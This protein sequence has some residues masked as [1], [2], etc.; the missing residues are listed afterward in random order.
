M[1]PRAVVDPW[2]GGRTGATGLRRVGG[3]GRY[4]RMSLKNHAAVHAPPRRRVARPLSLAA[5]ALAALSVAA[6]VVWASV[7]RGGSPDPTAPGVGHLSGIVDIGVL[8]FREGLETI[9]VLTAI[10]ASMKGVRAR[11]RRP[12]AVGTGVAFAATLV[13]WAVAIRIVDHLT[14][15]VPALHVQAATGLLAIVVLLVVMNWFFHKVYWTG[16]IRFHTTRKKRLLAESSGGRARRRLFWGLVA[17]GFTSFYRE[18]FE[19]VLFLQ[20]YRLR[21]GGAPV[22]YGVLVGLALTAIVA[23][24]TFIAN[25][26]LPYKRMLVFTGVM[27][28]GVLLVMV[29]E[30]VQEMQLA[31]WLPT[32]S[33][34]ALGGMPAWLGLWF[35]IFP[36]VES[37][38]AQA[39]AAVLVAGS[40][41]VSRVRTLVSIR[42]GAAAP[43]SSEAQPDFG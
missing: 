17:L 42:R 43:L 6:V 39:L 21:L 32:T 41:L 31:G 5:L 2:D 23:V 35:A 34:P 18:G 9:L 26:R 10:T 33:I 15:S 8:V 20:S 24:L 37:L 38:T 12:V 40:F 30:Q 1:Q 7:S 36:T 19:V 27:L 29:G 22:L 28:G 3:L 14:E 25:R 4:L 13:T 16:W 11:D